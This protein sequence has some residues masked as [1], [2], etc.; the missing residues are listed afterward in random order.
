MSAPLVSV[1]APCRD[2]VAT[3][4]AAI[5]SVLGQEGPPLEVIAVDDGSTDGTLEALRAIADPRLRVIE[6]RPPHGVSAARNAGIAV[7]RGTW[8]AFQDSDDLWRPGKLAAQMAR[9]GA[10]PE[11]I[12]AYCAMRIENERGER[13]GRVPAQSPCPEGGALSRRLLTTNVIST[14]TLIVRADALRR[15]GG[16]DAGLQALV[17]WDLALRL[18]GEGTILAVDE[19]LVVQRFSENSITHS[20]DRRREAQAKILEKHRALFSADP[21]VLAHHHHRLAGA[22][23]IAGRTDESRGHALAALRAAPLSAR[24]AVGAAR[25]LIGAL[26]RKGP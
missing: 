11:A 13:T 9:L 7:A 17:D 23:R 25:A 12:G 10:E 22:Y 6:N 4:P 14:Q 3:A 5:A 18:A 20:L 1:V 15:V 19:E 2:R 21:K 8:I 26:G 16:F 24:H